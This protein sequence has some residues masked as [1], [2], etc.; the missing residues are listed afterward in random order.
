MQ[1]GVLMAIENTVKISVDDKNC[2]GVTSP[3]GRTRYDAK[4]RVIDLPPHE[5]KRI[6]NSG[7]PGAQRYSKSWSMGIDLKAMEEER[8]KK[9]CTSN[10]QA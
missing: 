4:D 7:H 2:Y 3:D 5:A 6:L 1:G 9:A 10:T 8:R